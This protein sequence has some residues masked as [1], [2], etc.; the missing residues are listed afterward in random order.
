MKVSY[1]IATRTNLLLRCIELSEL[2]FR[3]PVN[4][5]YAHLKIDRTKLA[6]KHHTYL[7]TVTCALFFG[8]CVER[9]LGS[10][11]YVKKQVCRAS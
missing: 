1:V 4:R 10:L 2:M 9:V 8:P 3:A 5:L 6:Q 7:R 11:N